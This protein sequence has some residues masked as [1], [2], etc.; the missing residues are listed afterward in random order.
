M[1]LLILTLLGI[2]VG[3]SAFAADK[4][5]AA[6]PANTGSSKRIVKWVDGQGVTHYGD[7]LPAQEAGRNNSEMTSQGVVVKQNVKNTPKNEQEDAEK[8][9]QERKDSILMASYTKA[10]EIDMARDR[11]L[12]MDQAAIQALNSQ[13]DSVNGR[14]A[15]NSKTAEGIRARKK[16]VP[17]YLSD[18]INIA[19]EELARIDQQIAG[20]KKNMMDTNKRFADEKARFIALKQGSAPLTGEKTPKSN[21]AV[22]SATATSAK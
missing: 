2:F 16:P 14:L 10:E 18:E 12:Q 3:A 1:R 13:K 9:A 4:G 17:A 22:M 5:K 19:K 6:N 21:S 20:H 7:K 11:Y 15:R 8:L